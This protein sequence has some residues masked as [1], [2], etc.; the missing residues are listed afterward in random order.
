V[1]LLNS[2]AS[3]VN[4]ARDFVAQKTS[5]NN[6]VQPNPAPDFPEGF[7]FVEIV[8]GREVTADKVALI[9]NLMPKQPFT[10]GGEQNVVKE[11]YPGN[12]EPVVQVLNPQEDDLVVQGRFYDKKYQ[13]PIARG[14]ALELQQQIDGIR[15]RGNLLKITLGELVRY[16]FL[17]K[18]EFNMKTVADI[19]YQLTF[20]L[21][22][23]NAPRQCSLVETQRQV[24]FEINKE[25]LSQLE[26]FQ[27][28]ANAVPVS[29]PQSIADV[30]RDGISD[31]AGV[32]SA[33]T[34]FVDDI[35]S[36]VEDV[37]SVIDRAVGLIRHAQGEIVRFQQ[38][39]G[40]I[41]YQVQSL[42]NLTIGVRATSN[43]FIANTQAGGNDLQSLLASLRERFEQI[44]AT[45]PLSRYRVKAGDSLQRIANR[46]YGNSAEW[47]RIYD[48]NE[49]TST[50][51]EVG[52]I[53]EIPRV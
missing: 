17:Q 10:F 49:L 16:G 27:A 47:E 31:V 21:V 50:V 32:V 2:A 11:Y 3:S 1:S 48:H 36:Q 51:L 20:A 6:S 19:E 38:R 22:G 37:T 34:G 52:S 29:T 12:S 33:V 28:Q 43:G 42:Q 18:T 46:F 44:R 26:S 23:F 53:L 39:I 35:V 25:L 15:I 13:D 9:G 45:T 8:D 14:I 4:S 30:L 7:Q 5:F 24:P 41:S 40:R